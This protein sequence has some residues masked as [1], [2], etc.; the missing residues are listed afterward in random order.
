[1][2]SPTYKVYNCQKNKLNLPLLRELS[3]CRRNAQSVVDI[4]P[5]QVLGAHPAGHTLRAGIT[6]RHGVI[7][8]LRHDDDTCL[9]EHSFLPLPVH[10]IH[11]GLR[12]P[13]VPHEDSTRVVLL[14]VEQVHHRQQVILLRVRYIQRVGKEQFST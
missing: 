10:F 4:A 14:Y 3:H 9:R 12:P 11:D 2:A 1:V 7:L 6:S 5:G 8:L 13:R